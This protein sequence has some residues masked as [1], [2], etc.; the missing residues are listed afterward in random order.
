M[1]EFHRQFAHVSWFANFVRS[2]Q[3]DIYARV[4]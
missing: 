4:A 2:M 1:A 3:A